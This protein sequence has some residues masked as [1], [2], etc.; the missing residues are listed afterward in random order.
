MAYYSIKKSWL[1]KQRSDYNKD[2][3][4]YAKMDMRAPKTL[5]AVRWI[6]NF[7]EKIGERLPEQRSEMSK[8]IELVTPLLIVIECNK[9]LCCDSH[10]GTAVA[11]INTTIID[12]KVT[13]FAL[14]HFILCS[15][16]TL[17]LN[18]SLSQLVAVDFCINARNV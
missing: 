12:R 3:I 2:P 1:Y 7:A 15:T 5:D 18:T 9:M 4:T 17:S 16:P 13:A 11:Y 8:S 10:C 6:L 14:P